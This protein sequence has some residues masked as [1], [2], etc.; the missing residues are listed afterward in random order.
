MK[1]KLGG[2]VQDVTRDKAR[3]CGDGHACERHCPVFNVGQRCPDVDDL[4]HMINLLQIGVTPPQRSAHA[5][6]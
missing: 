4:A 1:A 5:A 3:H 2:A 6:A